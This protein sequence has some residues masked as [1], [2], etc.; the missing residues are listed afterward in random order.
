MKTIH[1]SRCKYYADYYNAPKGK[2]IRNPEALAYGCTYDDCNA[3]EGTGELPSKIHDSIKLAFPNI[4]DNIISQVRWS[5]DHWSFSL[6]GMYV[7]IE[8]DGYIHS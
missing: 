7:G 8:T 4:Y 5:G 1:C 3:C 6:H 2:V